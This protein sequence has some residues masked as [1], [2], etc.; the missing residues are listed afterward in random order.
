VPQDTILDPRRGGITCLAFGPDGQRLAA[1]SS[2]ETVTLWHLPSRKVE[3]TFTGHSRTLYCVAFSP[4]GTL[5]ASGDGEDDEKPGRLL[6]W[7]ADTANLVS[8]L[9]PFGW[10]VSA[11]AWSPDG[12]RI[13]S[14]CYDELLRVH[15]ARTGQ[16]FLSIHPHQDELNALAWSPDGQTL[17]TAGGHWDQPQLIKLWDAT[18]SQPLRQLKGH[19][20][21]IKSLAYAPDGRLASVSLDGTARIWDPATARQLHLF[22][23]PPQKLTGLA[24]NG[25]HIACGADTRIHLWNAN[26][27]AHERTLEGHR[28]PINC[29]T[30]SPDGATLAS[31]AGQYS[32]GDLRL[33]SI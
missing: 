25:Q 22:Q 18:T 32:E 29:L 20:A 21:E 28:Q 11:L 26:T 8:T 33:W 19:K 4:D 6:I 23:D 16:L 12:A 15:D 1:G 31:A 5:I 10:S 14:A 13:A 2:S 9:G 27:T 3:R 7:V 24:F 30:L 17:A